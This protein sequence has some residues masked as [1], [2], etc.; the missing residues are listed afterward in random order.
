M[1]HLAA[2]DARPNL[3]KISE[4]ALLLA[5]RERENELRCC[6]LVFFF[7]LFQN[8]LPEYPDTGQLFFLS[9]RSDQKVSI[10]T[11]NSASALQYF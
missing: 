2:P 3:L 10:I 5:K 4:P 1:V 11:R 8:G 6:A 7:T 9:L